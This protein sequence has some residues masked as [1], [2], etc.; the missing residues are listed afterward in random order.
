MNFLFFFLGFFL[1]LPLQPLDASNKMLDGYGCYDTTENLIPVLQNAKRFFTSFDALLSFQFDHFNINQFPYLEN[2]FLKFTY[3][4]KDKSFVEAEIANIHKYDHSWEKTNVTRLFVKRGLLF[5]TELEEL[6][7]KQKLR[8]TYE[9][10]VEKYKDFNTLWRYVLVENNNPTLTNTF[11][12]KFKNNPNF[13][14]FFS[15]NFIL[16]ILNT[17]CDKGYILNINAFIKNLIDN[18]YQL[19]I[20]KKNLPQSLSPISVFPGA[21]KFL[22]KNSLCLLKRLNIINENTKETIY[23]HYDFD[24]NSLSNISYELFNKSQHDDDALEEL[25]RVFSKCMAYGDQKI[26]QEILEFLY[27]NSYDFASKFTNKVLNEKQYRDLLL[28]YRDENQNTVLHLVFK[29]NEERSRNILIKELCASTPLF[30]GIRNN[31]QNTALFY[32]VKNYNKSKQQIGDDK[33]VITLKNTLKDDVFE[34]LANYEFN[35]D[36]KQFFS[37]TENISHL[38]PSQ[39]ELLLKQSGKIVQNNDAINPNRITIPK[40]TQ[41]DL[42]SKNT[43]NFGNNLSSPQASRKNNSENIEKLKIIKNAEELTQEVIEIFNWL[44]SNDGNKKSLGNIIQYR[45]NNTIQNNKGKIKK[46]A[47]IFAGLN[48]KNQK[49]I[50]AMYE[51]GLIDENC[52]DEFGNELKSMEFFREHQQAF[53]N[54]KTNNNVAKNDHIKITTNNIKI[55]VKDE[56]TG[57]QQS[58]NNIDKKVEEKSKISNP[59][60]NVIQK[61]LI[62]FDNLEHHIILDELLIESFDVWLKDFD[63]DKIKEKIKACNGKKIISSN[64]NFFTLADENKQ[65]IVWQMYSLGLIDENCFYMNNNTKLKICL[66]NA[67]FFRKYRD[68]L[69][70]ATNNSEQTKN[71][72]PSKIESTRINSNNKA[73]NIEIFKSDMSN[74]S[75]MVSQKKELSINLNIFNEIFN[76]PLDKLSLFKEGILPLLKDQG[77]SYIA[78]DLENKDYFVNWFDENGKYQPK[79]LQSSFWDDFTMDYFR[80]NNENL[81]MIH[82][83]I[84]SGFVQPHCGGF[85]S[86]SLE[87][88]KKHKSEVSLLNVRAFVQFFIDNFDQ[89]QTKAIIDSIFSTDEQ[90][91]EFSKIYFDVY[92]N[93]NSPNKKNLQS[94]PLSEDKIK[95]LQQSNYTS[96]TLHFYLSNYCYLNDT[97][98]LGFWVDQKGKR[99]ILYTDEDLKKFNKSKVN[100]SKTS[101]NCT[102]VKKDQSDQKTII[103][104]NQ[105]ITLDSNNKSLSKYSE[106]V[107]NVKNTPEKKEE[108]NNMD[109]R[110]MKEERDLNTNVNIVAKTVEIKNNTNIKDYKNNNTNNPNTIPDETKNTVTEKS[111]E[112]ENNTTEITPELINNQKNNKDDS[113]N[114]KDN[115]NNQK[116]NSIRKNGDSFDQQLNNSNNLNIVVSENQKTNDN[117]TIAIQDHKIELSWREFFGQHIP[118]NENGLNQ[119]LNTNGLSVYERE[120]LIDSNEINLKDYLEKSG[121]FKI[122]KENHSN[123]NV[124]R[125]NNT[126]KNEFASIND[127]NDQIKNSTLNLNGTMSNIDNIKRSEEKNLDKN[128]EK[129]NKKKDQGGEK[130]VGGSCIKII[131]YI[132][133]TNNFTV[134]K[135]NRKIDK[136]KY[137]YFP[138]DTHNAVKA[139][140]NETIIVKAKKPWKILIGEKD[141]MENLRILLHYGFIDKSTTLDSN[142]KSLSDYSIETDNKPL[143]KPEENKDEIF[144]KEEVRNN[145]KKIAESIYDKKN[146]ISKKK[147]V[148]NPIQNFFSNPFGKEAK[149]LFEEYFALGDDNETCQL[150][151]I[152]SIENK[153]FFDHYTTWFKSNDLYEPEWEQE[154]PARNSSELLDIM[155]LNNKFFLPSDDEKKLF[156]MFIR[157]GLI[158]PHY[159]RI[160]KVSFKKRNHADNPWW[161]QCVDAFIDLFIKKKFNKEQ[162]ASLIDVCFNSKRDADLKNEFLKMYNDKYNKC[163]NDQKIINKESDENENNTTEIT[164]NSFNTFEKTAGSHKKSSSVKS[165]SD[166][167]GGNNN[168]INIVNKQEDDGINK[169]HSNKIIEALDRINGIA[170]SFEQDFEVDSG[171]SENVLKTCEGFDPLYKNCFQSYICNNNFKKSK[172][173]WN[174]FKY[175]Q[176]MNLLECDFINPLM[177][178]SDN[179]EFWVY[180]IENLNNND[181]EDIFTNDEF[182]RVGNLADG[183]IVITKEIIDTFFRYLN[184]LKYPFFSTLVFVGLIKKSKNWHE[185][186]ESYDLLNNVNHAGAKNLLR[187]ILYEKKI[188][189]DVIQ[190]PNTN[191]H[192]VLSINNNQKKGIIKIKID[193]FISN[194]KK[195]FEISHCDRKITVTQYVNLKKKFHDYIKEFADNSIVTKA[196]CSWGD[197]KDKDLDFMRVLLHYNLVDPLICDVNNIPF[198]RY[199]IENLHLEWIE[200]IFIYSSDLKYFDSDC[201]KN[202]IKEVWITKETIEFFCKNIDKVKLKSTVF[203]AFSGIIKNSKPWH[204]VTDSIPAI[205]AITGETKI[206]KDLFEVLY[207]KNILQKPKKNI[208]PLP[209]NKIEIV[210]KK[211][212]HTT[213]TGGNSDSISKRESSHVSIK[214]D[215]EIKNS[216][217]TSDCNLNQKLPE[218][219]NDASSNISTGNGTPGKKLIIPNSVS[220]ANLGN[221]FNDHNNKQNNNN[222]PNPE[223]NV[224]PQNQLNLNNNPGNN[225]VHKKTLLQRFMDQVKNKKKEV[226]I[227]SLLIFAFISYIFIKK[228]AWL[229]K[230]S[231][232]GT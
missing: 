25:M 21:F 144:E 34:L 120:R 206:K 134:E 152:A 24:I 8:P 175:L 45:N 27:K 146:T 231:K 22:D 209:Q 71:N 11:F 208:Q 108:K 60:Q 135:C 75:E 141:G 212:F 189:Q 114:K 157:Y 20:N 169:N 106:G 166:E 176:L 116:D 143:S 30:A 89:K 196:L 118:Q 77:Q 54:K 194:I 211:A 49:S 171:V 129:P 17:Q 38:S 69:S 102:Q 42:S 195:H 85:L 199:C 79:K 67:G 119:Y 2:D 62:N 98:D 226:T 72:N 7:N 14:E 100:Q 142:N 104:T 167:K 63:E 66:K 202:Y 210:K 138:Q 174:K 220:V 84:K 178:D 181:I 191:K 230:H 87:Y 124:V 217:P 145:S 185:P 9:S 4:D 37:K 150:K 198:W 10:V 139:C 81:K 188:L 65:H 207:E 201:F 5:P 190:K 204:I 149:E 155:N 16:D 159:A 6:I 32:Y 83:I 110:G 68:N 224:I 180:C 205:N 115:L 61:K 97:F 148:G 35:E 94:I 130:S 158:Q 156:L 76:Q 162:I 40:T 216:A 229:L 50:L 31:D 93:Y 173:T 96:A 161:S 164:S 95:A 51:V 112:N 39:Q 126:Q 43:S 160:L 182:F 222:N 170:K 136:E 147:F 140:A 193:E 228:P 70:E 219:N 55:I 36:E 125:Q 113:T 101:E 232:L 41:K 3:N 200:E 128:S 48:I 103:Q 1:I 33:Y 47:I 192:V 197:F 73:S 74:S 187:D 46:S 57:A 90:K 88:Y 12:T 52:V 13:S 153:E 132:F 53:S 92:D 151:N 127:Q 78:P 59:N 58:N 26:K 56:N 80:I 122:S 105:S 203:T 121:W 225:P 19:N 133:D 215:W 165:N 213:N 223:N 184:D 131:P 23:T 117:S 91:Y 137:E 64:I 183:S 111:D 179:K 18:N 163:N 99:I 177:V 214:G 15:E 44:S 28:N 218:N 227:T 86:Q 123:E 168:L 82:K 107:G 109:G 172:K 154:A 29:E 186:L 221:Q